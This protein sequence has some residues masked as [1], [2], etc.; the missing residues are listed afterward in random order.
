MCNDHDPP[1]FHVFGAEFS[2]KLAIAD[3]ALL[4]SK[5]RIR[6]RDIRAVEAW[7]QKHQIALSLNWDLAR[8][9]A[10]P[11]KIED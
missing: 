8:A 11:Q 4:S 3:R 2:A 10:P 7:G 5:G 1:D 9:G 6:R